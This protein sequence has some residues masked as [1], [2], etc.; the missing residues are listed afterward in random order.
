MKIEFFLDITKCFK[1]VI[2]FKLD[3]GDW[4]DFNILSPEE[5]ESIF[6]K[7]LEFDRSRTALLHL[8]KFFPGNKKNI[9][10]QFIMCNWIVL[11]NRLDISDKQLNFEYV[12]CPFK[13]NGNCPF[14]GKGIVCIKTELNV[15]SKES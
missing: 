15:G 12:P 5:I 14:K 9:L 8:S 2:W 10:E 4:S 13:H 6:S 3:D 11:D 7:L 1:K